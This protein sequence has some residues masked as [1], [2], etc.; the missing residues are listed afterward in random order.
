MEK[1]LKKNEMPFGAYCDVKTKV[2]VYPGPTQEYV[3]KMSKE[4]RS[5]GRKVW[6]KVKMH[7]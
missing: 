3:D 6:K 4:S 7:G 2:L 5:Y 1:K